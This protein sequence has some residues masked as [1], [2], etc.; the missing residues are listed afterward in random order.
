MTSP[1]D[2]RDALSRA[3]DAQ[4]QQRERAGEVAEEI[5]RDRETAAEEGKQDNGSADQG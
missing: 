1:R 4:R 2:A 3:V 5:R